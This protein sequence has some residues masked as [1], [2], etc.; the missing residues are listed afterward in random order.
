MA[1]QIMQHL[2]PD[3][4]SSTVCVT[5]WKL[6]PEPE[7]VLAGLRASGIDLIGMDRTSRF[8]LRPWKM[9]VREMRERRIDILHIAQVRFQLVGRPDRPYSARAGIR[10]P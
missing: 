1:W 7:E 4:F 2:D 8:D 10:C 3:R 9:L 6:S 5:R